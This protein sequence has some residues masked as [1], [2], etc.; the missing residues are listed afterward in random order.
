MDPDANLKRQLELAARMLA[1]H[2]APTDQIDPDD[3][4]QLAECVQNLH[5]WIQ[6]GGFLP[7]AWRKPTDPFPAPGGTRLKIKV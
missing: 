3:A 1:A 2:D 5:A 7:E 6:R 4:A